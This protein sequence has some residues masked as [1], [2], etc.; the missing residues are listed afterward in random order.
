M[1]KFRVG[2]IGFA[3]AAAIMSAPAWL[4]AQSI[5]DVTQIYLAHTV[6]IGHTVLPR[7]NYTIE[8]MDIAGGDSP[9]LMFR[10]E[11]GRKLNV[12][13]RVAPIVENRTQPATRVL[14]YRDGSKF[15]LDKIWVAGWSYGFQFDNPGRAKKPVSSN[16]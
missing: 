15:Y 2:A 13:A 10:D 6:S 1:T 5:S 11:T 12:S 4:Q 3:I 16:N 14:F 9:V 8:K 7:G